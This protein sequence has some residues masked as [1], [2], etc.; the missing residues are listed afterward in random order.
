MYEDYE[1]MKMALSSVSRN[2]AK[3]GTPK[4]YGPMVFAVTG[5]GRVAQGILEVLE[6]LPHVKVDPDEL[7]NIP[8]TIGNDTKKIVIS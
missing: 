5:T 2:I 3:S 1:A 4:Q 6:Q 7:K 8:T